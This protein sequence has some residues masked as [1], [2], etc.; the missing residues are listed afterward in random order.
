MRIGCD[1]WMRGPE[2]RGLGL[3]AL[4][5]WLGPFRGGT[6]RSRD[7]RGLWRMGDEYWQ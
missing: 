5:D 6:R 1:V 4:N 3:K 7:G 2:G